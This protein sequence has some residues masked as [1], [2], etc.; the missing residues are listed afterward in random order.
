MGGD[1]SSTTFDK[2]IQV[3]NGGTTNTVINDR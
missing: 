2:L 1:A 3:S